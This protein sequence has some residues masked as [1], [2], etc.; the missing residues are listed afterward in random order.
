M[1]TFQK[2]RAFFDIDIIFNKTNQKW[3][4]LISTKI[5]LKPKNMVEIICENKMVS[6]HNIFKI[7]FYIENINMFLSSKFLVTFLT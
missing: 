3:L 5:Y 1:R 7:Y 6:Q 2:L 4:F